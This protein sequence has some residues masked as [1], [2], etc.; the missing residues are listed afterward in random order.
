MTQDIVDYFTSHGIRVQLSIGGITYTKDWNTA[1]KT[2]ATQL[3]LN[4]AAVATQLGAGIEIDYEEARSPNLDGLAAFIAAYRSVHPYNPADPAA[5]LTID[6]AAGDRWLIGITEKAT[7]EWLQVDDPVLDYA[8]AMVP[9][10]Q[11]TAPAAIANWQE[12]VDGKPQYDPPIL[13]LSPAMFTG[14][15][16]V[17]EGSRVRPECNNFGASLQKS[18]ASFVRTVVSKVPGDASTGMLGWMFWAAE[19]PSTRGVGT[20]PPNTCEGGVGVGASTY[21]VPFPAP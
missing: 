10:K 20:Q 16:Y 5:R 9:S 7:R 17:A 19:K 4:A 11:P 12:H 21:G 13:P 8:N 14:S 1:L 2:N 15:V 3:G 18:T 6:L